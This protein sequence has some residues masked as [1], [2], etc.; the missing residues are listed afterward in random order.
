M[1]QVH[2]QDDSK[3]TKYWKRREKNNMAAKR[4]R[5]AR[6]ARENQIVLR[7][8]FLEKENEALKESLA[9][10]KRENSDLKRLI[11]NNTSDGKVQSLKDE[12]YRL[13]LALQKM[14]DILKCLS[15]VAG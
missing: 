10:M 4:S 12:N 15:M 6:R 2:V 3:D 11:G 7:A 9:K 14:T 5:D 8:S 1:D 13:R